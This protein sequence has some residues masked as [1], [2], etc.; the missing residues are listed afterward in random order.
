MQSGPV[1]ESRKLHEVNVSYSLATAYTEKGTL[2]QMLKVP[3]AL[4]K[5]HSAYPI[6]RFLDY[7]CGQN[8]LIK[9]LRKYDDFMNID[10]NS[11]DPAIDKYSEMPCGEFDVLTCIDVLEHISRGQ[12][13]RVLND[14]SGLTRGFFFFAIDLVP[15]IKTLSDKRN[16]H[17]MLAPPDW[18]CQQI[19]SEFSCTRF[20][21]V[22]NFES[23][24]VFPCH[25]FGWATNSPGSQQMANVFFDSIEIFSKKWILQSDNFKSVQ[26]QSEKPQSIDG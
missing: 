18:W 20:L 14:I 15:A 13:S 7:G 22:G 8:G 16:A 11:F 6:T 9:L 3:L 24:E 21:Q 2:K 4:K 12:I 1:E 10:F 25:L 5:T 23:G 26:F 19:S 17:I